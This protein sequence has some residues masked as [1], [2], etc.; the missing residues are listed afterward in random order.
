MWSKGILTRYADT[1]DEQQ[2]EALKRE[3]D[4]IQFDNG[5]EVCAGIEGAQAFTRAGI[6]HLYA[7]LASRV[8]EF[9]TDEDMRT[10]ANLG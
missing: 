2:G 1:L 6:S 9:T 4:A 8:R 10:F 3:I 5:T 7:D